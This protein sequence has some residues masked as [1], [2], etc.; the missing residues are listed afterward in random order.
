MLLAFYYPVSPTLSVILDE[1]EER[2]GFEAGPVSVEQVARLNRETQTAAHK[3]VFGNS[4]KSS[5]RWLNPL[6]DGCAAAP[7][8]FS[9]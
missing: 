3:Q 8:A 1:V 4:R 2:T 5:N 9:I 6:R 7:T